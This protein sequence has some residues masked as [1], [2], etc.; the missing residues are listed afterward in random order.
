MKSINCNVIQDLLPSY[1]D[2]ISSKETNLLVEEHLGTCANCREKLKSI[3]KDLKI[4]TIGNQQEEIDYLKG[5]RKKK[6]FSIIIAV[7]I[8]LL[9]IFDIFCIGS[10]FLLNHK[11][12]MN[13]KD[14]KL[15]YRGEGEWRGNKTLEYLMNMNSNSKFLI[16]FCFEED[17]VKDTENGIVYMKLIGKFDYRHDGH[18]VTTFCIAEIDDDTKCVYLIDDKDNKIKIW[19]KEQGIL[20]ETI[21]GK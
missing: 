9:V 11:F 14:V 4:E 21:V 5:Y 19:D 18:S 17:I 8:T 1:C 20:T 3:N 12:Y 2:K 10:K 7:I 15:C 6:I 13:V 16:P